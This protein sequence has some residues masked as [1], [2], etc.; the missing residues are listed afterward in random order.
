MFRKEYFFF[1]FLFLDS[2]SGSAGCFQTR[3]VANTG[4]CDPDPPA[5]DSQVL[6]SLMHHLASFNY[7]LDGVIYEN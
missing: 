5:S 6:A 1:L 3:Y 4:V 2:V 7:F